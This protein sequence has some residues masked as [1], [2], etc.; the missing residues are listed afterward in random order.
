[1]SADPIS[2]LPGTGI[3]LDHSICWQVAQMG[4]PLIVEDAY[5]HP[6]LMNHPA[7]TELGIAAYLGLPVPQGT[8]GA[9]LVLCAAEKHRRYWSRTDIATLRDAAAQVRE[10]LNTPE[11][12]SA[13]SFLN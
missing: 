2:A 6:L 10:I 3:D 12:N 8:D 1:M 4:V 9:L 11:A 13:P 5:S 7:V